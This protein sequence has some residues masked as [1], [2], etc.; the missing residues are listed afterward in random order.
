MG[1]S[2][3]RRPSPAPGRCCTPPRPP[4]SAPPRPAASCIDARSSHGVAGHARGGHCKRATHFSHPMLLRC[5]ELS[6]LSDMSLRILGESTPAFDMLSCTDSTRGRDGAVAR[7]PELSGP[8]PPL[9]SAAW[10]RWGLCS[11]GASTHVREA[12]RSRQ[13]PSCCL[14]P[15]RLLTSPRCVGVD[16]LAC[17]F[18]CHVCAPW[19]SSPVPASAGTVV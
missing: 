10:P 16:G 14:H 5:M 17:P 3:C 11:E 18:W 1:H 13:V 9:P 2:Q 7:G 4:P 19:W 8:P 12:R 15:C 6:A